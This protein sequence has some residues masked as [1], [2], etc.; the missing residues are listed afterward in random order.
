MPFGAKASVYAWDRIGSLLAFLAQSLLMLPVL[1]FVDDYFSV[2]DPRAAEH[3]MQCFARL[4]RCLLGPTSV[5][6]HKLCCGMPLSVLG[7]TI[8][9]TTD[10]ATC[11]PTPDR[12]VGWSSRI[13]LALEASK[14]ISPFLWGQGLSRTTRVVDSRN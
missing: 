14:S 8:E 4:V 3:G 5:A 2:E 11:M 12:V 10:F 7:L 6:S 1:R 13:K 9:I